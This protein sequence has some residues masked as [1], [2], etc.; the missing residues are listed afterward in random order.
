MLTIWPGYPVSTLSEN[1][2]RRPQRLIRGQTVADGLCA[3]KCCKLFHSWS[4]KALCLKGRLL[5]NVRT[6]RQILLHIWHILYQFTD[7]FLL[8]LCF[9]IYSFYEFFHETKYVHCIDCVIISNNSKDFHKLDLVKFTSR[10]DVCCTWD[11]RWC[12]YSNLLPSD[13]C[14]GRQSPWFTVVRG[15]SI[16]SVTVVNLN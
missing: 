6:F 16:V 15:M 5:A 12:R 14:K 9:T 7:S 13:E 4:V 11:Y 8:R 10:S 1:I 3:V 2:G